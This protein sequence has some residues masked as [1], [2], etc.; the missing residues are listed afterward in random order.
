VQWIESSVQDAS[1]ALATGLCHA[2]A[3]ALDD[4]GSAT[5]AGNAAAP[6]PLAAIAAQVGD[7]AVRDIARVGSTREV[8]VVPALAGDNPAIAMLRTLI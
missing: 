6:D 3:L 8:L 4:A 5:G 7:L 1:E 2:A